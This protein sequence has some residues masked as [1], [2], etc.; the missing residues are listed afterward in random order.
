MAQHPMGQWSEQM[1]RKTEGPGRVLQ[2]GKKGA[3][4][5]PL[6]VRDGDHP[7]EQN[8]R[9]REK[10]SWSP[11]Q[12]RLHKYVVGTLAFPLEEPEAATW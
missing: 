12:T 7:L 5:S 2:V 6:G 11:R 8:S 9:G 10:S 1:Q 4:P 3:C